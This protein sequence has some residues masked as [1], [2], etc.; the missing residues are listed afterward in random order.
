MLFGMLLR[1]KS[2]TMW[3]V[4]IFYTSVKNDKVVAVEMYTQILETFILFLSVTSGIRIVSQDLG[5]SFTIHS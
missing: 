3:G 4:F 2:K 5:S 1:E